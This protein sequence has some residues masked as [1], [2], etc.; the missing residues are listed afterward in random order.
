[1]VPPVPRRGAHPPVTGS[2]T[3]HL[4]GEGRHRPLRLLRPSDRHDL[5]IDEISAGSVVV[6]GSLRTSPVRQPE[7]ARAFNGRMLD[8]LAE[9]GIR[10]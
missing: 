8:G 9:K 1:M 3:G 6:S 2:G 4:N 7:I 5:G 10:L